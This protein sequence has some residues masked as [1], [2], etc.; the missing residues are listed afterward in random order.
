VGR[1]DAQ[2]QVVDTAATV[3]VATRTDVGIMEVP[4]YPDGSFQTGDLGAPV[5]RA[6]RP[7]KRGASRVR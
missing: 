4:W 3:T 5:W 2:A 6:A 1:T 7:W